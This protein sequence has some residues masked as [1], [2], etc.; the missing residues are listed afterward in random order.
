MGSYIF[1]V[2]TEIDPWHLS[3]NIT[4]FQY[5]TSIIWGAGCS[6]PPHPRLPRPCVC[7][8]VQAALSDMAALC[9]GFGRDW[10]VMGGRCWGAALLSWG[11]GLMSGDWIHLLCLSICFCLTDTPLPQIWGLT[12][13]FLF[14]LTSSEKRNSIERN[15]IPSAPA[16][17]TCTCFDQSCE[18][19]LCLC[20]TKKRRQREGKWSRGGGSRYYHCAEMKCFQSD[21]ESETEGERERLAVGLFYDC[22]LELRQSLIFSFCFLHKAEILQKWKHLVRDSQSEWINR[23][24]AQRVGVIKIYVFGFWRAQ[25]EQL[26]TTFFL[27]SP[28]YPEQ[29]NI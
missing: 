6:A 24:A 1:S 4:Y 9:L 23:S 3:C 2:P 16:L 22:S 29:V 8:C 28:F 17:D 27:Q 14:F 11:T 19:E 18:E 10:A 21:R 26:Y 25:G 20:P 13:F 5:D 15:L 7:V 12:F